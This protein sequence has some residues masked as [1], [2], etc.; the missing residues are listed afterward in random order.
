MG[1]KAKILVVDDEEAFLEIMVDKLTREGFTVLTARD[2]Q[3][4]LDVALKEHPSVVLLDVLMPKMH[5]W[6]MYNKLRQDKWGNGV[7]VIILTNVSNVS[8][9]EEGE[10]TGQF[11]YCVK[12]EY[13]LEDIINKIKN[14][15]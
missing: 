2:G 12:T 15:T 5:G 13:N 3:E 8:K 1:E 14:K 6:D 9:Q 11:E 7:P 4:G 10:K